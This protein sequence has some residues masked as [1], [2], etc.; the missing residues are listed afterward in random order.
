MSNK[1]GELSDTGKAYQSLPV[2][3]WYAQACMSRGEFINHEFMIDG[4]VPTREYIERMVAGMTVTRYIDGCPVIIACEFDLD[5][6]SI[7]C[8]DSTRYCFNFKKI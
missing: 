2:M 7:A 5:G 1:I 8:G 4:C 6:E 3:G